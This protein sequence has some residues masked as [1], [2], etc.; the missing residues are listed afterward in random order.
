MLSAVCSKA[1]TL[2][3]PSLQASLG[4]RK[5]S[6]HESCVVALTLSLFKSPAENPI[7][8]HATRSVCNEQATGLSTWCLDFLPPR[9]VRILTACALA[10]LHP[11]RTQFHNLDVR[12]FQVTES[13]A[14]DA[15]CECEQEV[16]TRFPRSRLTGS[17]GSSV[18]G[19][20]FFFAPRA[21]ASAGV[22]F[23]KVL[24]RTSMS[25][26][27]SG[28]GVETA[29]A[30][31]VASHRSR[32]RFLLVG[33]FPLM[34]WTST[35]MSRPHILAAASS[36]RSGGVTMVQESSLIEMPAALCRVVA[37]TWHVRMARCGMMR[38]RAG[39]PLLPELL[40]LVDESVGLTG[41]TPIELS[42][43]LTRRSRAASRS[44]RRAFSSTP[45]CRRRT[46]APAT[47]KYRSYHVL[48]VDV[49]GSRSPP[50]LLIT[51]A[52]AS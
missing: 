20:F 26:T 3:A 7:P 10:D 45:S 39:A 1:R 35:L 11:T 25:A 9:V 29:R 38:S 24:M 36:R 27:V 37:A 51:S 4:G 5:S 18:R 23:R 47:S 14:L 31:N 42:A 12:V 43:S 33:M 46:T 40:C 30:W 16:N 50:R 32:S 17:G 2:L 6:P 19:F 48:K 34:P 41:F 49:F 21:N 13:I 8:G 44:R 15:P 52:R 22:A 28:R